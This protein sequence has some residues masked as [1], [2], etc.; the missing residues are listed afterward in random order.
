[1]IKIAEDYFENLESKIKNGTA[2]EEDDAEFQ[3]NIEKIY[4]EMKKWTFRLFYGSLVSIII[5][6]S[7][8]IAY[9]N[10][11]ESEFDTESTKLIYWFISGLTFLG[12][13]AYGSY[14][15]YNKMNDI[16]SFNEEFELEED[17]D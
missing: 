6:I 17:E 15:S 3:E 11:Y 7:L 14:F 1:M 5:G 16:T 8:I 12:I 13:G 2:T 10:L 4:T 9:F